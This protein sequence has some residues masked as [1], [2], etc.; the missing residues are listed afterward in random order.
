MNLIF[1]NLGNLKIIFWE[2]DWNSWNFHLIPH[3][4]VEITAT[5]RKIVWLF[6]ILTGILYSYVLKFISLLDYIQAL[7]L[8]HFKARTF[9]KTLIRSLKWSE[10][11]KVRHFVKPRRKKLVRKII[12]LG[13]SWL[14]RTNRSSGIMKTREITKMDSHKG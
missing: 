6:N 11:L 12:M 4:N 9:W 1:R 10:Y 13:V 8:L 3:C 7:P 2:Q 14:Q 5:Q